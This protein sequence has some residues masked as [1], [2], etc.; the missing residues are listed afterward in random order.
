VGS[1]TALTWSS[2]GATSFDVAFGTTNPPPQVTT[3]QT[4]AS[5][6]PPAL[7]AGTQFFWQIVA[8]NSAGSTTGPIWSFTTATSTTPSPNIVIYA[9]DIPAAGLHGSWSVAS[10]ATSPN[11]TKLVTT[12]VG[13]ASTNNPLASPTDYVDVTFTAAAGTPYRLWLRLQALGNSKFNDAVWVQF[14]DAQ[15]NGAA[16]YPI[17]NT[18]GLDVN[19]ATD[20][21]AASLN[22]W[23]WQNT[24]YWLSQSTTLTFATSGT[25]TMRIQVREDGVQFDQIV[26]SP[27]QYLTSAPGGPTND[28]TIVAK[29]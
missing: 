15:V 25:H 4:S 2:A 3:G 23:G 29:P 26:L 7:A 24:A 11:G 5:Y 28:A 21:T 13:W 18:S 22:G 19:L 12:D 1:S 8:R 6:T 27:S 20:G 10:D 17:N 16:I 9:S 14:S